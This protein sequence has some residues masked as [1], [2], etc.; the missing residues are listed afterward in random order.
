MSIDKIAELIQDKYKFAEKPSLD[1][2]RRIIEKVSAATSEEE[3][4][5]IVYG[6]LADA[7]I[8]CN[9]AEDMSDTI[10]LLKQIQAYLKK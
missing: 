3:L 8:S 9:E 2:T 7:T 6:N 5:D 4:R 1:E 10:N